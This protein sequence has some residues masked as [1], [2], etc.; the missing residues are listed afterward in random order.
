MSLE[1][2]D[3]YDLHTCDNEPG[4]P[5]GAALERHRYGDYVDYSAY[6]ELLEAYE[7]RGKTLDQIARLAQ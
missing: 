4:T 6:V 5:C 3:R 2:P 7:T 1:N